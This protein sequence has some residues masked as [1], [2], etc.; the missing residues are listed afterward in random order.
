MGHPHF[1]LGTG[2]QNGVA[3]NIDLSILYLI[4]QEK[5]LK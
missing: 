3:S 2:K 1:G 4:L 5:Y